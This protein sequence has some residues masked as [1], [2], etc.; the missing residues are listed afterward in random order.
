MNLS[1]KQ[2]QTHRDEQQICGCQGEQEGEGVRCWELRVNSCKLLHLEWTDSEILPYCTGNYVQSLLS[3][4]M[5]KDNM[6][7]RMC[8]DV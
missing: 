6:R 3:W 7:K 1:T 2:K 4:S 5:I 8:I